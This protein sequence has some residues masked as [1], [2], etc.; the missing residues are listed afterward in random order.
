MLNGSNEKGLSHKHRVKVF[1][2][3]GVISQRILNE[4]DDVIK[5]KSEYLVTHVGTND[6]TNG[7]N[8]L[9]NAKKIVKKIS[10]KLPNTCIAFSNIINKKDL[11]GIYKK[12]AETNQRLKNYCRQMDI[13][14]VESANINE[15]YLDVN[16]FHLNCK[17]N[18]CFSKKFLKYINSV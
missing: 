1:D 6:L 8:L 12:L 7:I 18:S 11:K 5:S 16:K 14:Y 3:P 13:S 15:D 2:K 10:E 4:A 9:N 17:G